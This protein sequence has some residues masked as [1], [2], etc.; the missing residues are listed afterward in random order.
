MACMTAAVAIVAVLVPVAS[1][2]ANHSVFGR[3][4]TTQY[5]CGNGV[6]NVATIQFSATKSK[7]ILNG[8][9]QIT[10]ST[11]QKFG[12]LNDGTISTSSYSVTGV[13]TFDQ[14]RRGRRFH[15][16]RRLFVS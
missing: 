16:Q 7:G 5:F 12:S 3:G 15:R 2:N 1:A 6:P 10:G 11:V 14:T 8:Q 13:A 9:F 4:T